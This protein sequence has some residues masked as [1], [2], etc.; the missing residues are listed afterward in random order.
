MSYICGQ[1]VFQGLSLKCFF[2]LRK[3]DFMA[4]WDIFKVNNKPSAVNSLHETLRAQF[5]DNEEKHLI[6]L[7]C[8]AGL[9]S[10]VI[11]AD[12]KVSDAE[13]STMISSLKTWF[14]LSDEKAETV[15]SLAITDMQEHLGLDTRAYCTPLVE[16]Y[17]VNTR[18]NILKVLFHLAASCNGVD[19][20]ESNEINYIAKALVL[21]QKHFVA[22]KATVKDSLNALK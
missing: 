8:L 18:Y 5:P 4:F 17:D 1:E 9:M 19:N 13:K 20:E 12:F 2:K 14:A 11:Y 6:L 10:K 15:A 3:V 16:M 22:A 7:A 21:E